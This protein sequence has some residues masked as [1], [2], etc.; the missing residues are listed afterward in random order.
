[1]IFAVTAL[2]ASGPALRGQE[3]EKDDPSFGNCVVDVAIFSLHPD[4]G[5]STYRSL[6]AGSASPRGECGFGGERFS[7]SIKGRL[8][9][10]RFLA[11]VEIKPSAGETRI[12][13]K[14]TEYDLS[15][16]RA[17]TLDIARDDD[18]RV[19]RVNLVPRMQEIAEPSQFRVKDLRLENWSFPGSPVVLNDQDYI[20]ELS[21]SS[22]ALAWCDIPGVAKVEFSLLQLKDSQ[23]WGRLRDGV[24]EITHKN[25]TSLKIT[26]VKNGVHQQSLA[27]GPYQVWIR[28]K[29]PTQSVEEYRKSIKEQI[30]LIGERAKKG[31]LSLPPG[32]LQRL[33]KLRESN[34]IMLMSNGLR[35]VKPDEIVSPE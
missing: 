29:E 31:D 24:I 4:K 34:R 26:N 5:I 12:Q 10:Q 19:Y 25:G 23:P 17:R 8:K 21:M 27:G 30:A 3:P 22:G 15:D 20:G 9:S 18:G 11:T 1:M 35:A 7:V 13:H 14:E 2:T 32:T 28:W 33:E 6:G 16:L